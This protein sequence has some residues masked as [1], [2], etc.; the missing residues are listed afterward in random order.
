[1]FLFPQQRHEYPHPT[2]SI[3]LTIICVALG[4]CIYAERRWPDPHSAEGSP[5]P[6]LACAKTED[7]EALCNSHPPGYQGP[8]NRAVPV[9]PLHP[10]IGGQLLFP[11]SQAPCQTPH[12]LSLQYSQAGRPMCILWHCLRRHRHLGNKPHIST[13][14]PPNFSKPHTVFPVDLVAA[15]QGDRCIK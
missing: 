14:A 7:K 8:F 13:W 15:C 1:M 6:G 4:P 3:S 9:F 5:G 12:H 10:Q 2:G 11:V